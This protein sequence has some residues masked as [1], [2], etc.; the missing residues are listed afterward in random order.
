MF[1]RIQSLLPEIEDVMG[2]KICCKILYFLGNRKPNSISV[3]LECVPKDS[4]EKVTL[5][6]RSMGYKLVRQCLSPDFFLPI[7]QRIRVHVAGNFAL[8]KQIRKSY[9]FLTLFPH[10]ADNFIYFPVDRNA[11][12]GSDVHGII[13]F[14]KDNGRTKDLHTIHHDPWS[15]SGNPQKHTRILSGSREMEAA[16]DDRSDRSDT[17][18]DESMYNNFVSKELAINITHFNIKNIKESTVDS[19]CLEFG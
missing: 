16:A 17:N 10:A 1:G 18:C 7:N 13:S 15:S 6:R 19:H 12:M 14:M 2:D 4:I 3:M 9:Y 11:V 5:L 8:S